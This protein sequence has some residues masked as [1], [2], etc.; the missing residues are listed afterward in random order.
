MKADF[1]RASTGRVVTAFTP[2]ERRR[3]QRI[4]I[5]LEMRNRTQ[6]TFK[7]YN[8]K[9]MCRKMKIFNLIHSNIYIE[10]IELII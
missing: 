10:L 9:K 1:V 3:E 4:I 5:E 8:G 6:F 2:E 7:L